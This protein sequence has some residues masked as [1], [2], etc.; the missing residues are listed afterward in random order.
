MKAFT[1]RDN[2]LH[3]ENVPVARI[4]E[5]IG[6]PLYV[7]S[8]SSF[9]ARYRAIAS[10]FAE[11]APTICY[12][13]KSCGN[14]SILRL[15]AN[16]GCGFD[17]TSAGEL[18]RALR[19]G[20][21]P[22]KTIFAGVGKRD[23]E[24]VS[25][26]KSGIAAF[27]VESEEEL[28]NIERIAGAQSLRPIV[29]ALRVNP[30]VDARTHAK[31]TTG[32]KKNKFGVDI[33]RVEELFDRH[34]SLRHVKLAGVHIHLGSPISSVEPYVEAVQKMV[35][36]IERLTP[37]GHEIQWFDLGGGFGVNYRSA[38]ESPDISAYAEKLLP[39]LRGKPFRVAIEPG[40][41]IAG[42][43]GILLAKVLYRKSSGDKNFVITDAGM[44][45]LLRPTLYEAYHHVWPVKVRDEDLVGA[46]PGGALPADAE[47][48]DVVG[49]VCESGDYLA[50]DRK[51]PPTKRLDLLAVFAAGAYGFAMSSN[52]NN[53][54]RAAEVLVE[55]SSFRVIRKRETLE[56]LVRLEE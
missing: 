7:Y 44:N 49:P 31:T 54:P 27:N 18:F 13:I 39:L 47:T 41:Y 22:K 51:L 34:K 17:V 19:A 25:G 15:L 56:D 52:Y 40:R 42:E 3:C 30:D 8:A 11:L 50:I 9:V 24:I 55:G 26:I 21:D 1:Y 37:R 35:G 2:E 6:T 29:A 45:D 36:L 48:V 32:K 20:G 43:S 5:E 38:N 4:A 16:E 53:R 12:S 23:D 10:A 33:D 28:L 46:T 14:L